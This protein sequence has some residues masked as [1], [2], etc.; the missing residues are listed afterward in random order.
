MPGGHDDIANAVAGAAVLAVQAAAQPKVK[1]VLPG[2]FSNGVWWD[3]PAAPSGRQPTT[4]ELF[5][6]HGSSG[7]GSRWPGSDRFS[8]DW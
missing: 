7:G 8:H 6:Q 2:V 4:T 3:A 5:Y 1:P